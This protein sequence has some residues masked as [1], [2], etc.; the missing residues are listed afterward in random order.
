[1][2]I[3]GTLR[4]SET[5]ESYTFSVKAFKKWKK[6]FQ[7]AYLQYNG[8][9]IKIDIPSSQGRESIYKLALHMNTIDI[10]QTGRTSHQ[11]PEDIYQRVISVA[12]ILNGK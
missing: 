9:S 8:V 1:M 10:F 4:I 2:Q 3:S 7:E 12:D 5:G 6:V 11:I